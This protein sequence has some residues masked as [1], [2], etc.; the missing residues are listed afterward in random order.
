M[1]LWLTAWIVGL[2]AGGF[3]SREHSREVAMRW[4]P[5]LVVLSPCGDVEPYCDPHA[6]RS[7][8]SAMVHLHAR[9][10]AI[11]C[12]VFA[13]DMCLVVLDTAPRMHTVQAVLWGRTARRQPADA[14]AALRDCYR[15]VHPSVSL[16]VPAHV[17]AQE[18]QE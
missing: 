16:C 6:I 3:V 10:D 7:F 8:A 5:S 13:P 15:A 12:V 9:P 1:T 4:R 14:I 18:E 2:H 17:R 11:G